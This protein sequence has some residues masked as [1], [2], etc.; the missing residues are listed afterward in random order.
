MSREERLVRKRIAEKEWRERSIKDSECRVQENEKIEKQKGR[1]KGIKRIKR[2]Q[3][4]LLM[5]E[6]SEVEETCRNVPETVVQIT[7]IE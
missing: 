1:K 7:K 5:R 2:S 3:R 4:K 6:A